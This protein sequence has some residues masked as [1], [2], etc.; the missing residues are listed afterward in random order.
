MVQIRVMPTT[1]Y[2]LCRFFLRV[3]HVMLKICDT[4]IY[5]EAGKNY[6]IREW[7]KREALFSELNQVSIKQ[8]YF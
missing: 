1:F 6:L 3:D 7:S 5:G 2:I 8:R 4:R